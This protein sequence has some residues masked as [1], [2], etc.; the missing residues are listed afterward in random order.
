VVTKIRDGKVLLEPKTPIDLESGAVLCQL[1]CWDTN[2]LDW[3]PYQQPGAFGGGGADP[4]GIKDGAVSTQKLAVDATGKIGV[5]NFPSGFLVSEAK[6][7][8]YSSCVLNLAPAALATDV[9]V[10]VGSA[11][12]VI[13]ITRLI[14]NG[15]QTTA[16]SVSF[17]LL[18][19]SADDT[20]GTSTAL[21][22]VPHDS[23]D[24]A[25]TAVVRAYTA[26]PTGV[27]AL[28]GAIRT[29]N[30]FLPG[31][32]TAVDVQGQ[33]FEFANEDR[34]GIILRGVTQIFAV[35]L[36]GVTVVGGSLNVSIEWLE[37]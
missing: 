33:I 28:V 19:R 8:T 24:A 10:V 20:A 12:K 32:A 6:R 25:A 26:N 27:G 30:I 31:A 29:S 21:A 16:G 34:E 15:I 17:Q 7:A 5:N 1:Y 9:F 22:K 2:T 23:N 37:Y 36:N 13:A 11:T 14:I 3:V 35:N 4:I 18:K